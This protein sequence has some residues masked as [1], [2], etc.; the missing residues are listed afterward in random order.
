MLM[1]YQPDPDPQKMREVIQQ[2]LQSQ[3]KSA[4]AAGQTGIRAVIIAA[5]Q[6]NTHWKAQEFHDALVRLLTSAKTSPP[7]RQPVLLLAADHLA[8]RLPSV[9]TNDKSQAAH[10]LEWRTQLA[11]LGVTYEES[12]M[13]PDEN[14]WT[15]IGNLLQRVWI[16]YGETDWGER[17]FLELLSHGW[18][19]GV[20]CAAGSDEFR[21]VIQQGLPFLEKHAKSP[22]QLDVQLAVAQAYETWWSLS[23]APIPSQAP[24]G[25]ED[26]EPII[27]RQYQEGAEAARQQSIVRYEHLLQ[28]APQTD[29]AAAYARRELPRLKLGFDTGQRR[30]YCTVTD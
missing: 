28:T 22:Y 20:D 9:M 8:W 26:S 16:D 2:Q 12:T 21:Q 13:S 10:W 30:F 3:M 25:E 14:P 27:Y 4:Q 17:A 11:N 24:I 5:P 1:K 15:Y 18:D 23:L 19:T 29:Q 7:D 6:V